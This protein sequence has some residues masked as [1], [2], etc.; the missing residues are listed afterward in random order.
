MGQ[1]IDIGVSGNNCDHLQALVGTGVNLGETG[2]AVARQTQRRLQTAQ[3]ASHSARLPNAAS[4]C[5]RPAA[6]RP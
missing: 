2:E 5:S 3:A 6:S 1:R 4:V